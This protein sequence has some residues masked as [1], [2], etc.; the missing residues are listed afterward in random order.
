MSI[1]Q[2]L[3]N[4]FI[5]FLLPAARILAKAGGD[6][7]IEAAKAA[8]AAAEAK[9]GTGEEKF[10]AAKK[11]VVKALQKQGLPIVMN[12]V[13]LAIEAAVAALAKK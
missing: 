5:G 2:R 9:G 7:L 8:V 4:R 3:F 6:A 12:A 10:I 11:A 1:L 13:N